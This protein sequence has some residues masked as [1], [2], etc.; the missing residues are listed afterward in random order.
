[1]LIQNEW[2]ELCFLRVLNRPSVLTSLFSLVLIM[3][4][5]MHVVCVCRSCLDVSLAWPSAGFPGEL[6]SGAVWFRGQWG[7]RCVMGKWLPIM[8]GGP[9]NSYEIRKPEIIFYIDYG[10]SSQVVRQCLLS[11]YKIS[12]KEGAILWWATS[13]L[14]LNVLSF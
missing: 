4:A 14:L 8:E 1:M 10:F 13:Q 2:F 11:A 12:A 3:K 7:T 9:L 5:F 6:I